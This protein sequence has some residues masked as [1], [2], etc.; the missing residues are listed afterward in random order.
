MNVSSFSLGWLYEFSDRCGPRRRKGCRWQVNVA[1]NK[2]E[3][4]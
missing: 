2:G 3:V 1:Y 4:R